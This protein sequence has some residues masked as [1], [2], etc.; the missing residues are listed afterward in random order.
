MTST[1]TY[2]P[3]LAPL[4]PFTLRPQ[5]SLKHHYSPTIIP[6]YPVTECLLSP[7]SSE[8]PESPL[9][10][11]S[12]HVPALMHR[13]PLA[14][15]RALQLQ[16]P[17]QC[18]SAEQDDID[19]IMCFLKRV[20]RCMIHVYQVILAVVTSIFHAT[21]ST[22]QW[23]AVVAF[24]IEVM[25]MS[26]PS[27]WGDHGGGFIGPIVEQLTTASPNSHVETTIAPHAR[28]SEAT[29]LNFLSEQIDQA[30]NVL[31]L[32]EGLGDNAFFAYHHANVQRFLSRSRGNPPSGGSKTEVDLTVDFRGL[33]STLIQTLS[34]HGFIGR[35]ISHALDEV[36]YHSKRSQTAFPT[37]SAVRESRIDSIYLLA[38]SNLLLEYS[39]ILSKTE[40]II[41]DL[42]ALHHQLS[43]NLPEV[44]TNMQ[45]R[46]A[47]ASRRS[48]WDI[49]TGQRLNLRV[50]E[51]ESLDAFVAGLETVLANLRQLKAYLEW[52]TNQ[53]SQ[54]TLLSS[55]STALSS[56]NRSCS[57]ALRNLLERASRASKKWNNCCRCPDSGKDSPTAPT[58][59]EFNIPGSRTLLIVS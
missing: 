6:I 41:I 3:P 11:R 29:V 58:R 20:S 38:S 44:L 43:R 48:I 1:R 18:R 27:M 57:S 19:E 7:D 23:F 59:L 12:R 36:S 10:I 17:I 37:R 47:A 52:I 5:V 9:A 8:S 14:H 21:I 32:V 35:T 22:I 51:E 26:A 4:D 46:K 53:L 50:V 13:T 39:S 33:D 24:V 54:R 25:M 49:F 55:A 30:H 2:R 31:T 42:G 56:G 28:A 45:R 34:P 40:S 15:H 16:Q